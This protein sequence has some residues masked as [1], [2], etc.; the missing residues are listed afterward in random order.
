MRTRIYWGLI[1]ILFSPVPTVAQ[2]ERGWADCR[3]PA[4][5]Q[6]TVGHIL[7]H[8][9]VSEAR[10]VH[11]IEPLFVTAGSPEDKAFL[12]S[13]VKECL[14]GRKFHRGRVGVFQAFHYFAPASPWAERV[15]LDDGRIIALPH[16]ESVRDQRHALAGQ[17]L[18]GPKYKAMKGPGWTLQTNIKR[19]KLKLVAEA[20]N[21]TAAAFD[22]AFPGLPPLN[23]SSPVT[24]FVFS[25][26]DAF[27]QVA[28]FDRIFRGPQPAGFYK[29][30]DRTIYTWMDNVG[31]PLPLSRQTLVHEV[32]HHHVHQRLAS[33]RDVPV[34]V[35]EG[36][37][38]F[39]EAL[40]PLKSG[41]FDLQ[42]FQ[43]GTQRASP[44]WSWV[45]TATEYLNTCRLMER[46]GTLPDIERFL[47][48]DMGRM[49]S[50]QQYALSWLLVFYLIN[51]EGG[52]LRPRFQDWMTGTM[53]TPGDPGIVA[54][55]GRTPEQLR[56]T[57][58]EL[59]KDL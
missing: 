49:S 54:A 25:R 31:K 22:Q 33:D 37:A 42:N 48:G 20:I 4:D 14:S 24:L 44:H 34:W 38:S 18:A 23:V 57:I 50:K 39:V 13:T 47:S 55:L 15:K 9:D 56:K 51:G 8:F 58:T 10:V 1:L 5:R 26:E 11:S 16:L 52:I 21:L 6:G 43:K 12:V 46:S 53:G 29:P 59:I 19:K 41:R 40:R 45:A 30:Y 27:N 3:L 28:A 32:T 35:T 17:L 36:I 7:V 2:H